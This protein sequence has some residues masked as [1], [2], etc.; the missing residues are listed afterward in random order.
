RRSP[1]SAGR[2]SRRR[3]HRR[4]A[5]RR[6]A[7]CPPVDGPPRSDPDGQR[8]DGQRPHGRRPH[9]QRPRPSLQRRRPE[10][11][12]GRGEPRVPGEAG[13]R[14]YCYTWSVITID[15]DP[16]M[17]QL[18]GLVISWHGFFSTLGLVAGIWISVQLARRTDMTEDQVLTT[19][20]WGVVGAIVGA[21]LLHVLDFWYYYKDHPVQIL[22]LNE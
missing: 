14:P 4:A 11:S 7:R 17:F 16:V 19:A 5:P 18:G 20:L 12:H 3:P 21:R 9:G 13:S 2:A 6:R 1:G 15:I 10:G 22:L 8:P